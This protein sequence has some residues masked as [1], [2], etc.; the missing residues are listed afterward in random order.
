M[1]SLFLFDLNCLALMSIFLVIF[2]V[3]KNNVL[4]S[5]VSA[6]NIGFPFVNF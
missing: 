1:N 2:L 4:I 5:D 3:V 6:K